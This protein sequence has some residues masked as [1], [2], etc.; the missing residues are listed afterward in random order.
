M[1]IGHGTEYLI[2]RIGENH[3]KAIQRLLWRCFGLYRSVKYIAGKYK[4][5]IGHIAYY[6]GTPVAAYSVFRQELK[7]Y[8]AAQSADTM[9]D[10]RHRHKGLFMELARIT[11]LA[12]QQ[13]G[14]DFVFGFPNENSLPGFKKLGW[15][16]AGN[17]KKL[18]LKI[19]TLP[20]AELGYKFGLYR[21]TF[22]NMFGKASVNNHLL[23][24]DWNEWFTE[25]EMIKDIRNAAF[26]LGC[27][28]AVIVCS[29]NADIYQ[30]L[31]SQKW[32]DNCKIGYYPL[33]RE[34]DMTKIKITY[35]LI[36]TY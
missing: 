12:A 20:L 35:H 28:R 26:W 10:T 7:G 9:T 34:A 25:E 32:I 33:G 13:E 31:K 18:E 8:N 27:R 11:Y 5:C 15:Q 14:I 2:Y 21:F 19:N 3:Y 30:S 29:E 16:F 6:D 1:Y 36:D 24:A 17:L 4:H 22:N 23:I